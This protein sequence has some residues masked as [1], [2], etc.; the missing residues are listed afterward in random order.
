MNPN[1]HCALKKQLLVQGDWY[2][3]LTLHNSVDKPSFSSEA[4]VVANLQVGELAEAKAEAIR[5]MSDLGYCK[6]ELANYLVSGALNSIARYKSITN[7]KSWEGYSASLNLLGLSS[8]GG[9]G[10]EIRRL[11]QLAQL[12]L[13][14]LYSGQGRGKCLF[15]DCGGFDGCSAIKFKSEHPLFDVVTFE[16]NPDLW[17]Y[18]ERI[19]TKLIRKAVYI[20]DGTIS[21][22]VDI[23]D[24]DGSSVVKEKKIDASGTF[25]NDD[26]PQLSVDCI[27]L[28]RFIEEK[29]KQYNKI[30]LK[31]DIEGA[32]YEVLKRLI[33][34][35][36]MG[37]VDKLFCEFHW[38]KI[39]MTF[40]EHKEV[41]DSICEYCPVEDWDA[42]DYSI[43]PHSKEKP[44]V[45]NALKLQ[46]NQVVTL[47]N[48]LNV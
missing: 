12:G 4:V 48:K 9:I 14:P 23:Y 45:F 19:P 3:M 28:A 31:L 30:Y 16:A 32:E 22:S 34:T 47:L 21:F 26:C 29:A 13:P 40:E 6:S 11:E 46:R 38:N 43:H 2:Q 5:S 7:P 42:L 20:Y 25:S 44:K 18:Y 24:G 8:W 33:E 27:D 10:V 36:L 41:Y 17:H 1:K 39:G 37:V 15:I 35:G